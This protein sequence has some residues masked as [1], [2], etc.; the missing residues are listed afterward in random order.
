[1]SAILISLNARNFLIFQPILMT[2]VSKFMVFKALSNETYLLLGLRSPLAEVTRAGS[3]KLLVVFR[4]WTVNL[5][6]SLI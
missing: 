1:M 2:L 4:S 6:M 3:V 5:K